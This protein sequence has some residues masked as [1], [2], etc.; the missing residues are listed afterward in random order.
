M[1]LCKGLCKTFHI[2]TNSIVNNSLLIVIFRHQ[3]LDDKKYKKTLRLATVFTEKIS[4]NGFGKNVLNKQ[5]WWYVF[6]ICETELILM[7]QILC[8]ENDV[9][10]LRIA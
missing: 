5:L 9:I 6:V 3:S 2:A 1:F 8:R 10:F 4:Y 7:Q